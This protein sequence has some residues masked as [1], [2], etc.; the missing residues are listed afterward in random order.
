MIIIDSAKALAVAFARPL[1]TNLARLLMLR[2]G[3]LGGDVQDAACFIILEPPDT[4]ADVEA[5]VGFPMLLDGVPTWEWAER[6]DG[7]WTEVVFVFGDS[8]DV[9][10][11]PDGDD[12]DPTLIAIIQE[13]VTPADD[14]LHAQTP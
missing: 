3:Q 4:L 14:H 5:A 9:V 11:V 8:A 1:D 10:L 6:H 7:G 13:H 2:R 12:T